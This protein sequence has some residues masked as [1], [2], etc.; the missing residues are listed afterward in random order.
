MQKGAEEISPADGKIK[1]LCRSRA[2]LF[3]F[4]QAKEHSL[5][6]EGNYGEQAVDEDATDP[7]ADAEAK[8]DEN[9]K[10]EGKEQK[11]REELGAGTGGECAAQ[12]EAY[13]EGDQNTPC[14]VKYIKIGEDQCIQK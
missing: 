4:S 14:D 12:N 10:N 6:T 13:G 5:D 11:G 7:C 2:L 9:E 3:S 1:E 8:I